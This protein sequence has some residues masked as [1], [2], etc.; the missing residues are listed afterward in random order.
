M[1]FI[2][3]VHWHNFGWKEIVSNK[4][5][6]LKEKKQNK[7]ANIYI[8]PVLIYQTLYTIVPWSKCIASVKQCL[9]L[10]YLYY[11]KKKYVP[12]IFIL[13]LLSFLMCEKQHLPTLLKSSHMEIIPYQLS[14][15]AKAA[16]PWCHSQSPMS[17]S[18]GT[19]ETCE[20]TDVHSARKCLINQKYHFRYVWLYV[21]RHL[22]MT[23][24]PAAN[25]SNAHIFK[26]VCMITKKF[27]S[28]MYFSQVSA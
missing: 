23:D 11:K 6:N 1:C 10:Q 2:K 8:L 26:S 27:F 16:L 24:L 9:I 12:D 21:F 3:K 22:F 17:P 14:C 5:G 20:N 15:G 28:K 4:F 7:Q 18:Y 25:T 19:N 13:H